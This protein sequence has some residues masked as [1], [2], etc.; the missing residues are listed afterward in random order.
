MADFPYSSFSWLFLFISAFFG[1]GFLTI[2]FLPL[3]FPI[4][5]F[6]IFYRLRRPVLEAALLGGVVVFILAESP[7]EGWLMIGLQGLILLLDL[8]SD[9][10]R[11][12]SAVQVPEFEGDPSRSELDLKAP[13]VLLV[14]DKDSRA[15]PL[16]YVAHHEVINESIG[17]KKVV[18]SFCN[19][20]NAVMAY[21]VTDYSHKSGFA[22]ASEYGGNAVMKDLDT[23]TIWQQVTGE[24]LAGSLHPSRL[25]PLS[26]QMM[27]WCDAQRLI[28]EVKLAKTTA[29]ERL[30]FS[31][32]FFPWSRLQRS[33]YILGLRQRDRRLPARTH[34]LGIQ[35]IGGDV[36]YLKDEVARKGWVRNDD[37]GLL[38]VINGGCVSGFLTEV[39]GHPRELVVENERILDKNTSSAWNLRGRGLSGPLSGRDL[40]VWRVHDQ[41]WFAWSEHHRLTRVIRM[42]SD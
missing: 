14:V 18:I 34:V 27:P 9:E 30:P 11:I 42:E 1:L 5:I 21:D 28:P 19:Q 8:I 41:F 31:L 40:V 17:G 15:Y 24:S 25:Q 35:R 10:A 26:F 29:K 38:L 36:A 3:R 37:I 23:H 4:R 13:V 20:C 6:Y 7:T 39:D 2:R 32:K 12:C 33:N 16:T 22:I